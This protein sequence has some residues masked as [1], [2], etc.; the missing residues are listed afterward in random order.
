MPAWISSVLTCCPSPQLLIDYSLYP[1]LKVVACRCSTKQSGSLWVCLCNI[2][3]FLLLSLCIYLWVCVCVCGW[4]YHQVYVCK[5]YKSIH[6]IP[7]KSSYWVTSHWKTITPLSV[8]ICKCV[9][10][11]VCVCVVV[12]VSVFN[13]SVNFLRRT[14]NIMYISDSVNTNYQGITVENP[15][16]LCMGMDR[17][18]KYK[19]SW[20]SPEHKDTH[21]HALSLSD[22]VSVKQLSSVAQ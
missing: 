13:V 16:N 15:S 6:W 19:S 3:L 11:C 22:P 12:C 17:W 4:V 10:V 14:H 8:S 7:R 9:C 2:C 5:N 18:T 1:K 21:M 20:Q